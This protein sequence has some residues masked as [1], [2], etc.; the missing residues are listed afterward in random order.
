M[1]WRGGATMG[2]SRL[3]WSLAYVWAGIFLIYIGLLVYRWRVAGHEE[4]EGLFLKEYEQDKMQHEAAAETKVEHLAAWLK[5]RLV[6]EKVW[7]RP[8]E[9]NPPPPRPRGWQGGPPRAR[10]EFRFSFRR[11]GT[12]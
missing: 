9:R 3:V 7:A 4:D 2:P 11:F 8:A 6:F 5:V 1:L 10:C 12:K